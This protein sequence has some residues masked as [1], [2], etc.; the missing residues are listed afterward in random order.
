MASTLME[1]AYNGLRSRFELGEIPPGAQ[2]VNRTLCKELG[3]STI[4]LREAI[5]RLASEGLVEHIPNAGAFVR[6]IGRREIIQLFELRSAMELFGLEHA[7]TKIDAH[8]LEQ[9]AE[10]CAKWR[11]TVHAVRA[12]GEAVITG[13]KNRDWIALDVKFHKILVEASGNVWLKKVTDDLQ[14]M[15][16]IAT[17][18]PTEM[19]FHRAVRNYRTHSAIVRGLRKRDRTAALYWMAK[20]NEYG[21]Q[22]LKLGL[23]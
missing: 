8:Q 3:V 2:L 7:L 4:P 9:L 23:E 21:L 22:L 19:E 1:K 6:Q 11:Q 5:Q 16:Q 18:K 14:M 13:E 12:R 20:H 17:T 10:I 15:S